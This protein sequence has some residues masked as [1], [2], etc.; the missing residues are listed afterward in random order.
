[1]LIVDAMNVRGSVPDG[2]WRDRDA[3][4]ARLVEAIVAHEWN[5]E[6]VIVVADGRS[7][8]GVPAGTSGT[9]EVRYAGH[10]APDAADDLIAA[11]VA[12]EDPDDGPIT[13]VTSDQGLR[14]RLPDHV[15]VQGA[16]QFRNH[17]GW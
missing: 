1:M 12:D 13:V 2:W 16:R 6:W 15:R 11:I 9:V 7:V 4:L 3:A 10:S 5:D 17:V 8:A 14:A